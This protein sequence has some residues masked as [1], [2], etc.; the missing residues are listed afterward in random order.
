[1]AVEVAAVDDAIPV[2]IAQTD[3][4]EFLVRLELIVE[5]VIEEHMVR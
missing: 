5:M 1:M 2:T 3:E 4:T